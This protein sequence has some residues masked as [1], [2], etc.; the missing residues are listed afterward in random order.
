MTTFLSPDWST[1]LYI[2]AHWPVYFLE[3]MLLSSNNASN[4]QSSVFLQLTAPVNFSLVS[5][6][7]QTSSYRP[8]CFLYISF[9]SLL[10]LHLFLHTYSSAAYVKGTVERV[11]IYCVS[12]RTCP[13][14]GAC[15]AVTTCFERTH[16]MCILTTYYP[17]S[18]NVLLSVTRCN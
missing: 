11:V 15:F 4:S 1:S 17:T 10:S 13:Y 16:S 14:Q 6:P 18:Y 5:L 3:S 7:A 2:T 12:S 9:S 8:S